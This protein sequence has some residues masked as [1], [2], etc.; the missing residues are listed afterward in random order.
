MTRRESSDSEPVGSL[1]DAESFERFYREHLQ[2][3]T[4]F[5]T[6]RCRSPDEVADLVSLVFL[7]ARTSAGSFDQ[8][9]GTPRAWLLGIAVHC[10]AD[11]RGRDLRSL[12]LRKRLGG[13]A[14]FS[15]DEYAA[16]EARI[17][18]ERL[19]P[20][21]RRELL[22]LSTR[23]RELLR[24]VDCDGVSVA[25]AA[26]VLGMRPATG[27]VRLLRARRRVAG[28]LREQNERPPSKEV[29]DAEDRIVSDYRC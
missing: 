11:M 29:R 16:V 28:A 17:D 9:R 27:R 20:Q 12:E 24:L 15:H 8:N 3:L 14:A 22:R 26:R 2:A 21:V 1:Q 18:A 10:L 6:R 7:E 19:Y 5:A 13:E 23:D 25:D 4:R